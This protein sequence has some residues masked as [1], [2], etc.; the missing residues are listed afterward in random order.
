MPSGVEVAD[1]D[2]SALTATA[3]HSKKD[4]AQDVE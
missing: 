3:E 4:V 1:K 2:D